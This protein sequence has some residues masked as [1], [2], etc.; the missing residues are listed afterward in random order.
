MVHQMFTFEFLPLFQSFDNSD[1]PGSV[2]CISIV[3]NKNE[4][5]NK[6]E[7]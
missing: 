7:G 2:V 1:T 3:F 6:I 4:I 5:W